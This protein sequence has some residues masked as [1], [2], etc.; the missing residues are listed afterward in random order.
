[1]AILYTVCCWCNWNV[2]GAGGLARITY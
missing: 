1:M 2:N